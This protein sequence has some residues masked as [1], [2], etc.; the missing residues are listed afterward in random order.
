[1]FVDSVGRE[2][3]KTNNKTMLPK[4]KHNAA[5]GYQGPMKT[6]I[7]KGAGLLGFFGLNCKILGHLFT[8]FCI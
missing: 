1:M 4:P 6:E 7:L 8:S 5:A 2:D 3:K